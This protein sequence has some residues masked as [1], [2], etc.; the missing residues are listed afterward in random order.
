M[1]INE[2]SRGVS[3]LLTL[4]LGPLGLLYSSVAGGII[5]IIVAIISAPT[6]IGPIACWLLAIAIGDHATHKHNKGV[7]ELKALLA[8]KAE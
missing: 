5:L 4:L 6:I 3:F 8:N 2:K 7:R 1:N